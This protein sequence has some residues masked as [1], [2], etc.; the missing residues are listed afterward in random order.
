M[1]IHR[2]WGL[3]HSQ[4]ENEVAQ[5]D[6]LAHHTRTQTLT[7]THIMHV[8]VNCEMLRFIHDTCDCV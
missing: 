7:R 3:G 5:G 4:H 1:Y 8:H 6:I 2:K